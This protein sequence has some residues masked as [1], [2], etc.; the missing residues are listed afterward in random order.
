[1]KKII[2]GIAV[3]CL[4]VVPALVY[5]AC[6][7]KKVAYVDIPKVFN[8]F[9]MKKEMQEKYKQTETARA[10]VLDSLSFELQRISAQL[11]AKQDDKALAATFGMKRDY[12]FKQ[13]NQM[14]QDNT[15]L[16]SQYDKQIL[17]QMSQYIVDFG[18]QNHYDFIYGTEGNG[19]LMY[20]SDKFD[21]S[22]E[23]STFINNK[24]KGLE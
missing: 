14:E 22:D 10:K 8:A 5:H 3:L 12:Y 16:S 7:V 13:K 1:M 11:R 23:V 2:I 15:A 18:K 24:Y 17:E 21:I 6:F 19:T 4:A 20:A 9:A